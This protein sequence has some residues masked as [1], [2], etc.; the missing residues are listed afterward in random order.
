MISS[1]KLSN[2]AKENHQ[3]N[4]PKRRKGL[5]ENRKYTLDYNNCWINGLIEEKIENEFLHKVK[6]FNTYFLLMLTGV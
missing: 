6:V 3:N 2:S 5:K 4:F 1:E